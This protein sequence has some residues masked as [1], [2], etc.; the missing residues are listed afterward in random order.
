MSFPLS[1]ILN[2]SF[3]LINAFSAK[4]PDLNLF[5]KRLNSASGALS[6]DFAIQDSGA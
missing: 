1:L 6:L 4:F 2:H 3:S 5:R